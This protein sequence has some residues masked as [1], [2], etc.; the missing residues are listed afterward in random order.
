ML[1]GGPRN[2]GLEGTVREENAGV[3]AERVADHGAPLI[4]IVVANPR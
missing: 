4:G 3:G 1:C 2:E